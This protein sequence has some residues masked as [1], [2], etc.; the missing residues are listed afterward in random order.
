MPSSS[1]VSRFSAA[2]RAVKRGKSRV[3]PCIT[4]MRFPRRLR[5]CKL[6]SGAKKSLS[7]LVI[8]VRLLCDKSRCSSWGRTSKT[9]SNRNSKCGSAEDSPLNV[10]SWSSGFSSDLRNSI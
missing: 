2:S 3:S 9:N 6:R 10:N 8:R 1:V 7:L 4:S 5:V